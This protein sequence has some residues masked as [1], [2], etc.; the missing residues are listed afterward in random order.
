MVLG[1]R[2]KDPWRGKVADF[3]FRGIQKRDLINWR[4]LQ[5]CKGRLLARQ[6]RM[7]KGKTRKKMIDMPSTYGEGLVRN[8]IEDASSDQHLIIIRKET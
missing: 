5:A 7:F 4:V 8:T 1:R 3:A 6:S 2:V